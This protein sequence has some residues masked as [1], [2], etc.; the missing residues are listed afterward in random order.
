V[1]NSQRKGEREGEQK[2]GSGG[3]QERRGRHRMKGVGGGNT[4]PTRGLSPGQELGGESLGE[5]GSGMTVLLYGVMWFNL[6]LPN[7]KK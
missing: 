5:G 7:M 2:D 6:S 3:N 4:I 1:D